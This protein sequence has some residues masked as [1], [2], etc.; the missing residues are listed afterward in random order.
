M[1]PAIL[2]P[3]PNE[4]NCNRTQTSLQVHKKHE[5]ETD[6]QFEFVNAE[7][8]SVFLKINVQTVRNLTSNGKIPYYKFGKRVLYRIDEVRELVLKNKRGKYNGD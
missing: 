8:I 2:T 5:S 6:L 1:S 4:N 7:Q 3:V